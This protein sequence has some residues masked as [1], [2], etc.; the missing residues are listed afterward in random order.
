MDKKVQ[1]LVER[2]PGWVE[3]G[4]VDEGVAREIEAELLGERDAGARV[5][6]RNVGIAIAAAAMIGVGA[7]MLVSWNWDELGRNAKAVLAFLPWGLSM[8]LLGWALYGVGQTRRFHWVEGAGTLHALCLGAALALTALIFP[9][10]GELVSLLLFWAVL[11]LMQCYLTLSVGALVVYLGVLLAYLVE[12]N[13]LRGGTGYYWGLFLGCLPLAW[14]I[15]SREISRHSTI[16]LWSLA[17]AFLFGWFTTLVGAPDSLI[18]VASSLIYASFVAV[19]RLMLSRWPDPGLAR[20]RARPFG[21]IGVVGTVLLSL[22]LTHGGV[23][24]DVGVQRGTGETLPMRIVCGILALGVLGAAYWLGRRRDWFAL[25]C[26]ALPA[27]ALVCVQLSD[28]YG[29]GP[30]IAA[31]LMNAYLTGAIC[32]WM[33]YTGAKQVRLARLNIGVALVAVQVFIHIFD[34]NLSLYVG[35]IIFMLT[36]AL[37]L[38]LSWRLGNTREQQ[39]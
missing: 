18:I 34:A 15:Y 36:G 9:S 30:Y 22:Y 11:L 38:G 20:Y 17:A 35:A 32:L 6:R 33:I 21:V 13:G 19:D 39:P 1:W 7:I 10:G 27:V 25:C 23:W 37:M 29:W 4:V 12:I 31:R 28:S 14:V 24:M 26:L 2:L 16:L 8:G 3:A 5:R